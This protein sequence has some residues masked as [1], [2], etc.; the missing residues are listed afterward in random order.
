MDES[1]Q[2]PTY[3]NR[4]DRNNRNKPIYKLIELKNLTLYCNTYESKLWNYKLGKQI[5]NKMIKLIK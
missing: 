5:K 4:N 3:F 2:I 1:F